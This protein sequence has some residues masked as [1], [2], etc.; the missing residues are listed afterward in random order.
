VIAVHLLVALVFARKSAHYSQSSKGNFP[1]AVN[2]RLSDSKS[3]FGTN[4]MLLRRAETLG[5]FN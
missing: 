3:K 1:R 5:Y 2:L 4:R